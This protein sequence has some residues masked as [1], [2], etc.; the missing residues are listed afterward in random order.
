MK[1]INKKIALILTL[2]LTVNATDYDNA[3]FENYVSGQGVNDVI[4][5]AQLIVCK[6][7]KLGTKELA[8]DGSYKAT[9]FADECTETGGSN[10]SSQGTTAPTSSQNAGSNTGSSGSQESSNLQKEIETVFVNTG[11][12]TADTQTTKAWVVN[13]KPWDD[14]S[15]QNPKIF[16][17]LITKKQNMLMK[18]Q[19][20][21]SLH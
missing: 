13:D 14:Q 8:G 10:D 16:F 19:S 15:N 21:E 17:I 5:T 20:L 4:A 6:L 11:F 3:E 1:N 12:I 2:S 9:I 18:I 7:S